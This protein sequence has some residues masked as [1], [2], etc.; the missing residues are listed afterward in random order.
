MRCFI[1]F[2]LVQKYNLRSRPHNR[3]LPERTSRLTDRDFMIRMLYR[4]IYSLLLYFIVFL[5]LARDVPNVA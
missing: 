3:H 5:L 1:L 4:N 2:K